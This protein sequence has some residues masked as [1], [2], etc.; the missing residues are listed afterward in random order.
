[1][2]TPPLLL[3]TALVF[4]G[5]QTGFLV[6]GVVMGLVLEAARWIE[7]RWEFS[8]EDFTRIWKFC[9]LALLGAAVYAF[10]ANEGPSDFRGLF[11]NPNLVTQHSAGLATARTAFSLGR[12]LPMIFFLFVAAQT[13]STRGAIPLHVISLILRHR[14][15]TARKLGLPLPPGSNINIS[16]PFFTLCLFSAS[17]HA[18]EDST[19]FWGFCLLMAWALWPQRSPRFG[20]ALWAGALIVVIVLSYFGQRG[21]N[22]LQ[23]Y[24]GTLNPQ[25]LGAFS[26][27]RFDPTQS[28]T[29]IGTLGRIKTSAKIVIRLEAKNE[30]PPRRLREATYRAF[31][32]RTWFA[33]LTEND[34]SSVHETNDTTF[35]LLDKPTPEVVNIACYLPGGKALLPL[36]EGVGRLEHLLAYNVWKSPLGAVLEEGPGLVVFD[37]LY[38]PGITVDVP[39]S[40]TGDED[41]SVPDQETNAL[42]QVV[43][44]LNLKGQNLDQAIQKLARFFSTQFTYTTWQDQDKSPHKNESPLA[45][46]LLR[47]RTGHCEYF[48]TAAVLLLRQAG[49]PARYCVGYAV[50]EGSGQNYVVR[51]HD[52]HAWCLVWDKHRRAWRDFD[53]TP[54]SWVAADA[55]QVSSLQRLSDLWAR[56]SFEISRFR[57]GQTHIRQYLL[58]TLIPVL[59]LLLYQIIFRRRYRRRAGKGARSI[60]AAAWPGLDSEFYELEK[61]LAVSGVV[62][63]PS[64]PLGD[65]LQRIVEGERLKDI[66]AP[67]RELLGLHYRY[68][69]DPQGLSATERERLRAR[70]KACLTRIEQTPASLVTSE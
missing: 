29:E 58:L 11:H 65:W 41:L 36:P 27:R 21:I 34:F 50:H 10:T 47:S 68:R 69:F 55:F 70:A 15:K 48:A 62:R 56:V 35:L 7:T 9:S 16:Y 33:K 66:G 6:P 61:R 30:V 28:Q 5:W 13:Y 53:P 24:V 23:G 52:A 40:D 67:L 63:Q 8:D 22:Q 46:F 32:G 4:W 14:W 12:W 51:Q 25:W 59:A 19:F 39:P 57:W 42:V 3:G 43:A 31:K 37:A 45:R 26:R 2:K 60:Q 1:M 49:F 20:L 54:S 44:D 18:A 38:G 64:E 17:V